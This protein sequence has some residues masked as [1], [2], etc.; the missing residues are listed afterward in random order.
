MF[1]RIEWGG[2][3][4]ALLPFGSTNR[5]SGARTARKVEQAWLD[6]VSISSLFL[7]SIGDRKNEKSLEA[8]LEDWRAS[9]EDCFSVGTVKIIDQRCF[10]QTTSLIS[11]TYDPLGRLTYADYGAAASSSTRMT[12]SATG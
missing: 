12:Q 9:E 8:G 4:S 10:L 6:F 7:N 5:S 11:Y 2:V 1:D 3:P